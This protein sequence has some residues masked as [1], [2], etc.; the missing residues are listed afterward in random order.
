MQQEHS[1]TVTDTPDEIPDDRAE[2]GETP[3][4]EQHADPSDDAEPADVTAIYV[5]HSRT[6]TLGF[7]V[8][9]VVAVGALAGGIIG[10]VTGADTVGGIAYFAG[11]GVLFIGGPL[12]L[13]VAIVD[14]V[15]HRR[16]R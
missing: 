12:A 3:R 16:R 8:V 15:I 14:A 2:P 1:E 11:S 4:D 5:R 10:V 6:P 9:L 13:V 7:W